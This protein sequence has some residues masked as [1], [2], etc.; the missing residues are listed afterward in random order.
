[1]TDKCRNV[2]KWDYSLI[3]MRYILYEKN[4]SLFRKLFVLYSYDYEFMDEDED[5]E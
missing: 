1:M 5:E 4:P 2:K 3:I